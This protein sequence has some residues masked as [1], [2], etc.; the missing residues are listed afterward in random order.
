MQECFLR[1]NLM[2]SFPLTCLLFF[3]SLGYTTEEIY[4]KDNFPELLP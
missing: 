4:L 2:M 1:L 3:N